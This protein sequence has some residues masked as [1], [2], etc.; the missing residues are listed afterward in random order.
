[1]EEA[2][3]VTIF[4]GYV[5]YGAAKVEC[6]ALHALHRFLFIFFRI[7]LYEY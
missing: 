4:I 3:T 7:V 5:L 1:M 6:D 2:Y